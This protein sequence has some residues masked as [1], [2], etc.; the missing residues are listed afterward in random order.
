MPG[1]DPGIVRPQACPVREVQVRPGRT[2]RPEARGNCVDR[3]AAWGATRGERA[4][5]RRTNSIRPCRLASLRCSGEA[6][7]RASGKPTTLMDGAKAVMGAA[8]WLETESPQGRARDVER[9]ARQ[10]GEAPGEPK[11]QQTPHRAGVR[12]PIVAAKPGNAGGAKGGRKM[13]T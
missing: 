5:R 2:D 7:T 6:R 9:P 3:G 1:D 12:A 10:Q 13:E 4:I 11:A 8:R